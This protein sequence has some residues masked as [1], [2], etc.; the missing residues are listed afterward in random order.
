MLNEEQALSILRARAT[1]RETKFVVARKFQPA[2]GDERIA[3][4]ALVEAHSRHI[5]LYAEGVF[6]NLMRAGG[7]VAVEYDGRSDKAIKLHL[8]AAD[9]SGRPS[10]QSWETDGDITR[11]EALLLIR[12]AGDFS[13]NFFNSAGPRVDFLLSKFGGKD[14]AA[15]D[16]ANLQ[17]LFAIPQSVVKVAEQRE[18]LLRLIGLDTNLFFWSERHALAVPFYAANPE[19]ALQGVADGL[20]ALAKEFFV[21]RGKAPDSIDD[22]MIDELFNFDSIRTSAELAERLQLLAD[23]NSFLNER[24]PLPVDSALYQANVRISTLPLELAREEQPS[25]SYQ[26]MTLSKVISIWAPGERGGVVLIGVS[27]GE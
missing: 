14:V 23:F 27:V 16:I 24:S 12:K 1:N 2:P 18:Q 26:V 10:L 15:L 19:A 6:V 25:R 13:N 7:F 9:E 20:L 5:N 17:G 4:K 8:V 11:S 21:R 3:Q 22:K